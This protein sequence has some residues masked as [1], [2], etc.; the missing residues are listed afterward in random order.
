M[1]PAQIL[2]IPDDGKTFGKSHVHKAAATIQ[3]KKKQRDAN[4]R[5]AA[6]IQ[7]KKKQR[8]ANKRLHG[9]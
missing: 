9:D 2:I 5:S 6:T 8:D 1:T 3:G 7:G 4:K